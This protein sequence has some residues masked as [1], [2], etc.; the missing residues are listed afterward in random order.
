V[1]AV[2]GGSGFLGT[3]L[4]KRLAAAGKPFVILD[5]GPS[6]TFPD[7]WLQMDVRDVASLR[8]TLPD[9]AIVVNL[10]A[11][12]R[13]DVRPQSLYEEVNVAG[14]ENICLVAD[15]KRVRK[16][17]FTSSVACYGFC[18]ANTDESG[19]IAPF[20]EYGRTKA[21]AEAV[22][23]SWQERAPGERQL[24]VVRP[25]VIFGEQNRGNV[26]NLLKH[27]ASGKFVMVGGGRNTKSMA[28]VENVASFLE[29]CLESAA[30]SGTYNYVDKPDLDMNSLVST[31]REKLGIGKGVG[32]RIPY[33]AGYSIGLVFDLIAFVTRKALPIS[34]IRVKKFCSTTQFATS[35]RETGF[36]APFS[37]EEALARTINHEF[38]EDH[39]HAQVFFTE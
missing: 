21:R 5:K 24:V 13:D 18:P 20:N 23:R 25:T 11:E 37:L 34:S 4:C 29:H 6:A 39:K 12:H 31:V 10:A 36:V 9:G 15:E 33:W 1:I 16:I 28:Y 38:V 30:G 32:K 7:R 27:I 8:A 14:A 26:Y 3:R 17:I 35:V 2:I 22:F 19:A